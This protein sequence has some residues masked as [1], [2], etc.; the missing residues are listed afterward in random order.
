MFISSQFNK[1]KLSNY[2]KLRKLTTNQKIFD[3]IKKSINTLPR[4]TVYEK[5]IKNISNIIFAPFGICY[6]KQ[7]YIMPYF[8]FGKY[9]D[10]K[11]CGLTWINPLS[12]KY[13]IYCGDITLTYSNM[14][15]TDSALNHIRVT[16]FIIYNIT[17]PVNYI[18]NLNSND[19]LSNWIKNIVREV[20]STYSYNELILKQKVNLTE[21]I[22]EK[23]NSAPK[24]EFYGIEIQKIGLLK[25]NY[26]PPIDKSVLIICLTISTIAFV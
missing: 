21:K 19:V 6:V 3:S 7:N 9:D 23:I 24:T 13:K 16:L 18:I 10:Y 17:N 15:L 25:I 1:I 22:L 8:T 26:T 20:I 2:N 14:Y 12:K 5:L 11:T 4:L